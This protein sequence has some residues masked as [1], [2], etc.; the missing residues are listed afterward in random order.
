MNGSV[1]ILQVKSQCNVLDSTN[2]FENKTKQTEML[3]D[4]MGLFILQEF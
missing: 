1:V 4:W 3:A 2:N